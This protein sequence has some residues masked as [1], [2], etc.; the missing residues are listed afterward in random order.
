[1]VCDVWRHADTA[2][3]GQRCGLCTWR[4]CISMMRRQLH[5]DHVGVVQALERGDEHCMS[6]GHTDAD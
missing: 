1:M 4:F 2:L 5:T 3:R 6:V